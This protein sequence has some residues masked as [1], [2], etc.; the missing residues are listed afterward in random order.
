MNDLEIKLSP[1]EI[2][3]KEFNY[4]AKG[5]SP[6]EVDT[7]LD[8]IISDYKEFAKFLKEAEKEKKDLIDE[9]NYL[10]N[11]LRKMKLEIESIKDNSSLGK[12]TSNN[13]DLLRRISNLEKIVY[14]KSD[15]EE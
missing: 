5:Y 13:V 14:G 15:E 10:K 6:R 12:F 8:D 11:E 4:D 3:D 7:F 9:N 2:L 1:Q